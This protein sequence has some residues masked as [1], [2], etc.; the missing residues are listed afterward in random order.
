MH[1]RTPSVGTL[2][3]LQT[4]PVVVKGPRREWRKPKPMMNGL[5]KSDEAIRPVRAANKGARASAESS[6]ERASTKGNPD[7]QST[8]R[9][10]CRA[11][12]P[13]AAARITAGSG[14]AP[15]RCRSARRATCGCWRRF[16]GALIWCSFGAGGCRQAD[17]DVFVLGRFCSP[18]LWIG[19][20]PW[21]GFRLRL[22]GPAAIGG[23]LAPFSRAAGHRFR[24]VRRR[25]LG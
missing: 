24:A 19:V 21:I 2:G 20:L 5:K 4:A 3:G 15:C 22:S 14:R 11:S 10:Q 25:G 12:V 18:D 7:C 9:T 6:E 1:V 17:R 8:R 16:Q 13:Q 23:R